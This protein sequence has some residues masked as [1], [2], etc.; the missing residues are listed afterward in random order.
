MSAL[1]AAVLTLV[2]TPVTDLAEHLEPQRGPVHAA[3]PRRHRRRTY[4]PFEP[5]TGW[6][7]FGG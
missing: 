3:K 6:T 5:F 2:A 4:N 7:T 1:V